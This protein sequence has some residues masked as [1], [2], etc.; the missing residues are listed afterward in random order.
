M[1]SPAQDKVVRVSVIT[2]EAPAELQRTFK[3][4]GD[5]LQKKTGMVIRFTAVPDYAAVID[6][7]ETNT[8]DFAWLGGFQSSKYIVPANSRAKTLADLKGKRITFGARSSISNTLTPEYYLMKAGIDPSR[9]FKSVVFSNSPD[10]TVALVAASRA[11]AGAVDSYAWD[12]LIEA[13]N[14][15]VAKVRVLATTSTNFHYKWEVRPGLDPE[16]RKALIDG[17]HG[18]DP[19]DPGQQEMMDL[20]RRAS[21]FT[22]G[23]D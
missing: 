9:D 17:I 14:P 13:K 6:G 2:R 3:P 23:P 12:K 7:L 15:N 10:V 8:I 20:L 5:Y 18:L 1:G 4:L 21:K 16:L 22:P 11:D 19:A